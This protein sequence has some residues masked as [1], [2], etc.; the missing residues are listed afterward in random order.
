M[1]CFHAFCLNCDS[2]R[3]YF[4]NHNLQGQDNTV[5][6]KASHST[7]PDTPTESTSVEQRNGLF[8]FLKIT[9]G[10]SPSLAKII[11]VIRRDK[12]AWCALLNVTSLRQVVSP[13][14]ARHTASLVNLRGVEDYF[15]PLVTNVLL[16]GRCDKLD[17]RKH[18]SIFKWK[19]SYFSYQR[20]LTTELTM[21]TLKIKVMHHGLYGSTSCCISHRPK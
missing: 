8:C 18:H 3:P 2:V 20:S 12:R 21:F 1:L 14:Y 16:K 7:C 15:N 11:D 4:G 19:M 17:V 10:W 9:P 6:R 5:M 13:R